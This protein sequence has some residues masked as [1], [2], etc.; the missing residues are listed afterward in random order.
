[1]IALLQTLIAFGA[2]T[3]WLWRG[4]RLLR[5]Y[6][7]SKA[8]QQPAPE[9]AADPIPDDLLVQSQQYAHDW[10]R[11]QALDHMYELYGKFKDWSTVRGA[12]AAENEA[13]TI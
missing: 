12:L 13:G 6:L 4:E 9:K 2:I 1:M 3:L 10:A 11:Q 7:A 8:P 5:E